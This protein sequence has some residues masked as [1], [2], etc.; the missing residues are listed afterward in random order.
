MIYELRLYS[1]TPGRMGDLHARIRDHVPSL[2]EKHGVSCI[3]RWSSAA[4][5]RSPLFAYLIAHES[6]EARESTWGSLYSDPQWLSMRA[7]TNAGSE[8]IERY[9][10]FFL[11]PAP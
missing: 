8:M 3:G 10:L 1:V 5:P 7:A 6:Y 9:D 4:G 11:K 2:F